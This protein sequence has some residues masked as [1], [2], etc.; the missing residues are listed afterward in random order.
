MELETKWVSADKAY[1]KGQQAYIEF[2]QALAKIDA[3]QEEIA[4]RYDI[5]Q[6]RVAEAIAIGKDTR[7]LY[8]KSMKDLPKS[9]QGLY[10]LTTLD[11]AAFEEFAKPDTTQAK[12][13]E[14]KR[15]LRAPT[16]PVPAAEIAFDAVPSEPRP[17]P[18]EKPVAPVRPPCPGKEGGKA[19]E[20]YWWEQGNAWAVRP[21]YNGFEQPQ[22]QSQQKTS[23][24]MS[25]AEARK[26]LGIEPMT[27]EAL[28]A[29]FR[30][31][32]SQ[33]HPDKG[34]SNGTMSAI[35][36]AYERLQRE[37]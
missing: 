23:L 21:E 19:G 27:S 32:A 22:Q 37:L 36:Q 9:R 30:Y 20:Y 7:I 5:H 17:E 24:Q 35:N 2:G 31:Q 25:I 18:Y 8:F 3:T 1:A 6:P 26:I 11:D 10:L 13:L 16:M 14:Y 29:V 33:H 15:R 4:E 34:G 28:Q 12:I